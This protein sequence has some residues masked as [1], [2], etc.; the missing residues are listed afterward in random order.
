[1]E[2]N[3][4]LAHHW[5]VVLYNFSSRDIQVFVRVRGLRQEQV[6]W[7]LAASQ[8]GSRRARAP[9]KTSIGDTAVAAKSAQQVQSSVVIRGNPGREDDKASMLLR[10]DDDAAPKQAERRR[11]PLGETKEDGVDERSWPKEVEKRSWQT[12]LVEIRVIRA[13][14]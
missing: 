8:A 10:G 9:N 1:M 7:K 13:Q 3:K 5:V 11:K 6:P 4:A 12:R 14:V 2:K